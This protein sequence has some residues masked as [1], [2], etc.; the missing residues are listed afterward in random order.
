MRW[1]LVIALSAC[2]GLELVEGDG[3]IGG[4]AGVI[5]GQLCTQSSCTSS[6]TTLA[7]IGTSEGEQIQLPGLAVGG[8]YVYC[9]TV[10]HLVRAPI[11]GG[12]LEQVAPSDLTYAIVADDTN[13]YWSTINSRGVFM[14]PHAGGATTALPVA[15]TWTAPNVFVDATN[16]YW[17]ETTD[18]VSVPI[19]GG[20]RTTHPAPTQ[21]AVV[22]GPNVYF[23]PCSTTL[24][25][26]V[27]A[28]SPQVTSGYSVTADNDACY[29]TFKGIGT[30]PQGHD[31]I[32]KL[33]F[34]ADAAVELAA[35]P[36]TESAFNGQRMVVDGDAVYFGSVPGGAFGSLS[37]VPRGGGSVT[38]VTN[39]AV[40]AYTV[41]TDTVFWA[42]LDG[43]NVSIKRMP[44][45][46]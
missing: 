15:Q 28:T 17:T 32:L 29:W 11:G 6:V 8:G 33:A 44:K 46:H 4:E 22:R 43:A 18:L 16:V 2:G 37:R 45:Y 26:G 24:A 10:S 19:A 38:S 20:P 42:T 5:H 14:R 7:T 9:S 40:L 21:D 39:D 27:A 41:T 36:T 30:G 1:V 13:V 25:L 12:P 34:G 23:A 35:G 3:G 31:S